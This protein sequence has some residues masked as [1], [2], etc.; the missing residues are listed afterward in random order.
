MLNTTTE[1]KLYLNDEIANYAMSATIGVL[2]RIESAT[3][4][5]VVSKMLRGLRED[6]KK[7]NNPVFAVSESQT[8]YAVSDGYDCFLEC[9]CY[10]KA[11]YNDYTAINGVGAHTVDLV[12]LDIIE[13][14]ILKSGKEKE[15]NN[16]AWACTE[17]RK[18]I[19]RHGQT[20]F[21]RA[22]VECQTDK[23]GHTES[24]DEATDRML[25]QVGRYYDIDNEK[26]VLVYEKLVAVCKDLTQ[27]Q[28]MILHYRM[29]GK[30]VNEIA[31]ILKVKH[32]TISTHLKAIQD[33]VRK[34]YPEAVAV[35]VDRVTKAK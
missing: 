28:Q 3:A 23:D 25:Y 12:V 29:Q 9:Y 5:P 30:S 1:K 31:E 33:R 24:P 4:D 21:K 15:K 11:K 8:G 13:K 27:R 2:K 10:L 20:D 19:Y 26:G 35:C 18:Y 34:A 32:N 14:R 17:V 22:Y 7:I 6:R 16:L